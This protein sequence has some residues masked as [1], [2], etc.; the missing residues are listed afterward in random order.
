MRL[1]LQTYKI[2]LMDTAN[3]MT[4]LLHWIYCCKCQVDKESFSMCHL[5][6]KTLEDRSLLYQLLAPSCLTEALKGLGIGILYCRQSLHYI[7]GWV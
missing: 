1:R 5:D 6:S 3:K 7:G 4:D 2:C